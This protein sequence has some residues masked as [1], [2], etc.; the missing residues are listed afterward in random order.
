MYKTCLDEI[1]NSVGPLET[2]PSKDRFA[3]PSEKFRQS[4]NSHEFNISFLKFYKKEIFEKG[5]Y[6]PFTIVFGRNFSLRND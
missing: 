2:D 4:E 1:R 3:L 5:M 6:T